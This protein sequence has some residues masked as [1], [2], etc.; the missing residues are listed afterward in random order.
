MS[1]GANKRQTGTVPK[2]KASRKNSVPQEIVAPT[3]RDLQ[4]HLNDFFAS[5]QRASKRDNNNRTPGEGTCFELDNFSLPEN[6]RSCWPVRPIPRRSYLQD[7]VASEAHNTGNPSALSSTN[8]AIGVVIP[9]TPNSTLHQQQN[10]LNEQLLH[11]NQ[12]LLSMRV[13]DGT[14]QPPRNPTTTFNNTGGGGGSSSNNN[15]DKS[16]QMEERI[17]QIQDYIRITT[18]LIDS[19]NV[20]KQ[21]NGPRPQS[22]ASVHTTGPNTPTYEELQSKLEISNRSIIHIKEQQQQLLRLQQAAKNRLYEMEQLRGQQQP[23]TFANNQNAVPDYDNVEDVTQDVT[24]L[25]SRMKTLTDF[26]HSQND[27]ANS[28]GLD[29]KSELIEEQ[30]QLQK[31]LVDLK[32]KKQQMANLV[33]ELHAMNVQA[34]NNFDDGNR[35]TATPPRNMNEEAY[36]RVRLDQ[37]DQN[38]KIDS[39]DQ[40]SNA[41]LNDADEEDDDDEVAAA[42]AGS[43]LQDKISEINAMKDQLKRLQDMMHTVKL[44]EIKNGDFQPDDDVI[45]S[46]DEPNNIQ[47]NDDPQRDEEEQE[48]AE[49]VR[50]LHSMTNDLREQAVTLA[51]ERDRLKDIKNEMA[52]RREFDGSSEKNLKQQQT[53]HIHPQPSTST[54]QKEQI[55]DS[56]FL[57]KKNDVEKGIPH[58][59]Q[60]VNKEPLQSADGLLYSPNNWSNRQNASSTPSLRSS[61]GGCNQSEKPIP[62]NCNKDSTDA[63]AVDMLNMSIE[64]G[65]LQ[66]CSSRGYSVPPPMRN[67]SGRE[68]VYPSAASWRK[69]SQEIPRISSL[70]INNQTNGA[71]ESQTEQNY[72]WYWHNYNQT[73]NSAPPQ[74]PHCHYH[75]HSC[76]QGQSGGNDPMLMQQFIQ[77]QQM[78]INSISQCNQLLW[79][80]QREINNLNSAVLLIQERLLNMPTN[81]VDAQQQNMIRA[82]SVPPNIV[83]TNQAP[84]LPRAQSEQ[85][86]NFPNFPTTSGASIQQQQQSPLPPSPFRQ[87]PN[88]AQNAQYYRNNQQGVR[89]HRQPLMNGR[90]GC[91]VPYYES[92]QIQYSNNFLNAHNLSN[93]TNDNIG[94]GGGGSGGGSGGGGSPNNATI[95]NLHQQNLTNASNSATPVTNNSVNATNT[96]TALNN[97]VVPGIRANNYYDNFRSYSRQNLLSSASCKSNEIE[98]AQVHMTH[99]NLPS[100]TVGNKFRNVINQN[101]PPDVLNVNQQRYYHDILDNFSSNTNYNNLKIS[102]G[103]SVSSVAV[104]TA[105]VASV[106]GTAMGTQVAGTNSV[107][108]S[109]ANESNLL[110]SVANNSHTNN[111]NRCSDDQKSINS[112]NF[113][114]NELKQPKMSAKTLQKG[115]TGGSKR[116]RPLRDISAP[117]NERDNQFGSTASNGFGVLAHGSQDLNLAST[118]NQR[119][120]SKSSSK[121]FDDLKEN[122]YL[123]VSALIAANESR[124]HFLINLFRELQLISSSDPLRTRLMQAFQEVYTQHCESNGSPNILPDMQASV[125]NVQNDLENPHHQDMAQHSGGPHFNEREGGNNISVATTCVP[126]LRSSIDEALLRAITVNSTQNETTNNCSFLDLTVKHDGPTSTSKGNTA[127]A[128]P[129][130]LADVV[131]MDGNVQHPTSP[132]T[133]VCLVSHLSSSINQDLAEADQSMEND[134]TNNENAANSPEA[135]NAPERGDLMPDN[136]NSNEG[137]VGGIESSPLPDLAKVTT[138]SNCEV[139]FVDTDL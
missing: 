82:E 70:N 89:M 6:T 25:M 127:S 15:N 12:Q 119:T 128:T 52:R 123:E 138:S 116:L 74:S 135:L 21:A 59:L 37:L 91:T 53:H 27:M 118:S 41:S 104:P 44:I 60:R 79:D 90:N 18:S 75:H 46:Q 85:P 67:I 49:R 111:E 134:A 81:L 63:G 100:L 114:V 76:M 122:V 94:G 33:S 99:N 109:I 57:Q 7:A 47:S 40:P 22:V 50:V 17:S 102:T 28:L 3:R 68:V 97:Q 126:D 87:Y 113:D 24:Q 129:I 95:N 108:P 80:Q 8:A 29:E 139:D 4:Q 11:H 117:L 65:S 39:I 115:T 105:A 45:Q 130:S 69:S 106:L 9:T 30:T 78:L 14:L 93:H 86:Q 10:Q 56:N 121:L 51:A 133:P 124:P 38:G 20:E 110:S 19:I 64:A 55:L 54:V 13:P 71:Y 42:A 136:G 120:N 61:H 48:M 43:M 31:K 96:V 2:A 36:E 101:T 66:S 62:N 73:C 77:T 83:C 131:V 16:L 92:D 32:N 58:E 107:A 137:A 84:F 26:I 23:L 35:S 132:R 72:P 5:V 112:F 98:Q 125:S 34:E 88:A 103:S 1:P